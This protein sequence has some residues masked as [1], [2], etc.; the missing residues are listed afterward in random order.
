MAGTKSFTIVHKGISRVLVSEVGIAAAFDPRTLTREQTAT[1]FKKFSGIWDTGATASVITQ[2]IVDGLGLQPTGMTEV[3]HAHGTTVAE[4]Y[5]VNIGLPNGVGL[6]NVKVTK[7]ELSGVDALIGM[8]VITRGDFAVSNCDGNTAFTY[9]I[10]SM[11][12]IDFTG[13]VAPKAAPKPPATAVGRNDPCPCGS[14][15][16]YK[17][18]CGK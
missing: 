14:G 1:L 8:D 12:C 10:P 18:C 17:K 13:K 6:A 5:L 4:T 2:K 9:R 16:K 15:Q 11:E 7:G 3:H